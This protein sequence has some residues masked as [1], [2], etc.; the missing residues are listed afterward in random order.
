MIVKKRK[1][2]RLLSICLAGTLAVCSIPEPD[3]YGAQDMIHED[4]RAFTGDNL[5]VS[6]S[7]SDSTGDG[8][9]ENP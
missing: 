7:G 3:V 8:T 2:S 5:Y 6:Q 1:R 4:E 9:E